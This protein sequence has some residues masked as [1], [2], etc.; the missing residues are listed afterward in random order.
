MASDR[1][2]N[3]VRTLLVVLDSVGVGNAPDAAKYRDEG[4]NTLGHILL[5]TPDALS[6]VAASLGEFFELP[7]PWPAACSFLS[8]C[9]SRA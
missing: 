3:R 4:A 2:V 1:I 5:Q 8:T 7:Q 9:T 6:N